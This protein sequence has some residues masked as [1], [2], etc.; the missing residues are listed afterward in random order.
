MHDSATTRLPERI[1]EFAGCAD[2]L[3]A[4]GYRLLMFLL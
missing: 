2:V 4:A 1:F 3:R